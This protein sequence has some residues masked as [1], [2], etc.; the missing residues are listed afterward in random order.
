MLTVVVYEEFGRSCDGFEEGGL[1]GVVGGSDLVFVIEITWLHLGWRCM[2][3]E[4]GCVE[5]IEI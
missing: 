4:S 5:C 2:E 3:C 1:F